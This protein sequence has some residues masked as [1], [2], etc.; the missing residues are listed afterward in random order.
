MD[1]QQVHDFARKLIEAHGDAA[2]A[3]AA[4]KLQDAEKS[5]DKAEIDNWR[6]IRAAVR[7]RKGAH[8]S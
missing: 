6:R 5:G 7:E 8:E 4:A 1:M 3:E 2:E